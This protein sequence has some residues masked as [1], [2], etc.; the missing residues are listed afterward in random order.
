MESDLVNKIS[1]GYLRVGPLDIQV[2]RVTEKDDDPFFLDIGQLED[3]Y[4]YFMPRREPFKAALRTL[5]NE[6]GLS[7][8]AT[9]KILLE[10]GLA[11]GSLPEKTSVV[12]QD[13]DIF[14]SGG[15]TQVPNNPYSHFVVEAIAKGGPLWRFITDGWRENRANGQPQLL[16]QTSPW[17]GGSML[18]YF[19]PVEQQAVNAG[20]LLTRV[21]S[22]NPLTA[23]VALAVLGTLGDP[24]QGEKPKYPLLEPVVITSDR[25][26]HYKGIQKW[27]SDRRV[28]QQRI[29][30]EMKALQEL[31]VDVRNIPFE[32]RTVSIPRCKLFDVAEVYEDQ[33]TFDGLVDRTPVGWS[34]RAG[35]WAN[36]WFNSN[37]RM[38]L[39]G[40]SR[41]LLELDHRTVRG[42]DV[43]A[44]K[45]GLL[46]LAVP[47]GTAHWNEPITRRVER[48]MVD[49]GELPDEEHRGAHWANRT[50]ERLDSAL[51][52]LKDLGALVDYTYS[53]SYPNPGDRARGWVER[54]LSASITLTA[55]EFVVLPSDSEHPAQPVNLPPR[56]Q[57]RRERL[58]KPRKAL[59]PGQALDEPTVARIRQ[60]VA[61]RNMRLFELA[62]LVGVAKST[63]SNVLNRREAPSTELAA[64]IRTFLDSQPLD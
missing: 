3:G 49:I 2:K 22:L 13:P 48:L 15:K 54:W 30:A 43:V 31:T 16:K 5:I 40:M 51:A 17:R 1:G 41:V 53:E 63:L 47:G 14:Q 27:G 8:E 58:G 39:S 23:D 4:V 44:K 32:G 42:A 21:E 6:K 28:L 52:M 50:R 35:Q 36:Y 59:E 55:P 34:I 20:E 9:I 24:R 56:W 10:E 46:L 19:D 60:T 62:A 64:K 18:A 45:I 12:P 33:Y 25:I 11:R 26:L 38:W 61:A 29:A 37:G 7:L 57:R